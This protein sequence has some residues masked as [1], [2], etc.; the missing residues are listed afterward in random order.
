MKV[1]EWQQLIQSMMR[2]MP[3]V[4]LSKTAFDRKRNGLALT[5]ISR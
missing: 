4:R 2:D 1:M 3:E 5:S